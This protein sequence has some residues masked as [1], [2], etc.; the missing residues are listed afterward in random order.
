MGFFPGSQGWFNTCKSINVLHHINQR[1]VKNHM[2]ISIDAGKASD[3]VQH[4]FMIKILTKVGIAE[5]YLNTIKA[6]YDKPRPI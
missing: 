4:P 5:T 2:I 6:I 1:R 3:K